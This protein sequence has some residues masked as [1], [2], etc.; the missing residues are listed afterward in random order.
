MRGFPDQGFAEDGPPPPSAR[1]RRDPAPTLPLTPLIGREREVA[2]VL[3]LL[4]DPEIRLVT[5]TGPGGVGKTRLARSAMAAL[6]LPPGQSVFVELASVHDVALVLAT[7]GQAL[8]IHEGGGTPLAARVRAVL[9][10]RRFLLVLDNFE[11]VLPAATIVADLLGACPGLTA[12]VTSRALLRVS[13]ERPLVVPPLAV[14]D[15]P[16]GTTHDLTAVLESDAVRLFVERARGVR[17][18]FALTAAT[19]A[20]VVAICRALDGLPLAIELAAA[21]SSVLGPAELLARLSPRLPLLVDGPRDLPARQQTLAGTI[22][23]SHTLLTPQQQALFRRLAVFAGGFTVG[24]AESLFGNDEGD[25]FATVLADLESLVGQSLLQRTGAVDTG[26]TDEPR[27]TMLETIREYA[28]E[29]LDASGEAEAVRNAHA[30]FFLGFAAEARRQIERPERPAAIARVERELDNLRG[31][32]AWLLERGDADAAQTLATDLARFW[33]SLGLIAEGR[34]WLDRVLAL[35]PGRNP[36]ARVAALVWDSD[37]AVA[38]GQIAAARGCADKARALAATS[39]DDLGL[40]T[41]IL[42]S[43]VV[44][45]WDG[46]PAAAIALMRDALERFR[47]LGE[48][49]WEGIALRYLGVVTGEHGD[50]DRSRA[51]HQEALALWRRLDHP[52][53]VPAALRDLADDALWRGDIATALA[54]YQESLTRWGHLQERLHIPPCLWGIARVALAVGD[55]ERSVRLLAAGDALFVAIGCDP[56]PDLREAFTHARDHARAALGES[57]FAAAWSAGSALGWAEAV[58]E[59]RAVASPAADLPPA[60]RRDNA[61][62]R[63]EREV[64]RLLVEGHSDRE[65]GAILSISPRTAAHHVARILAKLD[66]ASRTAAASHAVRSGLV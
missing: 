42:Q 28:R 36:A 21:R 16:E 14:P 24:Y 51:Y 20:P 37:F 19:A 11:Q 48:L 7:I 58:A 57:A 15:A 56:W 2:A 30:V 10:G 59:A 46:K 43:G 60:A 3:N 27:L 17:P 52:W 1:W 25:A 32:L 65:I 49:V 55:H 38:Q 22:S 63:R 62:S 50:R 61:L 29:R 23:W 33:Q 26:D 41:A 35:P 12:L 64:L 8:G 53:G 5:L 47:A 44:E 34:R 31:A 13:G 40:A 18:D 4:R 9:D 6:G 66:V 45:D 54:H 39:G